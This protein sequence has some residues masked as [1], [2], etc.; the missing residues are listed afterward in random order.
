MTDLSE[1]FTAARD[2]AAVDATPFP[3]V[4][5]RRTAIAVPEGYVLHEFDLDAY[6]AGPQR[7]TDTTHVRDTAS[8]VEMV[9]RY[10]D[11]ST[12]I[13]V[14]HDARK[15]VAVFDDHSPDAARLG[16]NGWR[17]H[18]CQVDW[19]IT[20]AWKRWT[21]L[22]RQ[23]VDQ[24]AFAEH[25]EEGLTEIAEPA[26][27]D[28]LEIAQSLRA[29]K[30]AAWRS[31]RRLQNGEAK[32]EYVEEINASAGRTGDMT[33]P[34]SFTLVL[35]VLEGSEPRMVKARLRFRLN[36]STLR[37]GYLL[38]KP[39]EVV[40]AAVDRELDEVRSEIETDVLVVNGQP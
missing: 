29:T 16:T 36:G 24:E 31:E 34:G 3:V 20:P 27:A 40:R 37:L 19:R 13:Y 23:M 18:R 32:L 25:I 9:N 39:D 30:S 14:D 2:A 38:D 15:A 26:G 7:R 22:D 28:L 33:I 12:V 10:A 1:L 35:P 4:P 17:Q 6:A 11:I 8:F 5:D 21:G